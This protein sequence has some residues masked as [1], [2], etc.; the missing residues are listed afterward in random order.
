[1]EYIKLIPAGE[2]S[3]SHLFQK[4]EDCDEFL[5][6][7]NKNTPEKHFDCWI[8]VSQREEIPALFRTADVVKAGG[9]LDYLIAEHTD[10]LTSP[11]LHYELRAEVNL[12]LERI[13]SYRRSMRPPLP[14]KESFIKKIARQLSSSVLGFKSDYEKIRIS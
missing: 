6:M 13:R 10:L 9:L 2:V 1:M 5:A 4:F 12:S 3:P 7:V 14:R 11:S 8:S